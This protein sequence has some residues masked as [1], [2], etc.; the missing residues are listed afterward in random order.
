MSMF[1]GLQSAWSAFIDSPLVLLASLFLLAP[2]LAFLLARL[3]RV[4]RFC[5]LVMTGAMLGLAGS[6]IEGLRLQQ[7][8][9]PWLQAITVVLL[10][11]VGQR[12]SFGWLRRNP[13]L[14]MTSL[15]EFA[16]GVAVLAWLMVTLTDVRLLN[17]LIISAL[18]A[19]SSPVVVLAVSK[20]L[21]TRGQVTER[22]ILMSTLSTVLAVLLLQACLTAAALTASA[23]LGLVLA[24]LQQ[25]S[26]AFLLGLAGAALLLGIVRATRVR[27]AAQSMV[28][29]AACVMLYAVSQLFGISPLLAALLFGLMT[30]ALDRQHQVTNFEFSELGLLLAIAFFVLTGVTLDWPTSTG[31]LAIGVL[32]VLVR[33]AIKA[34]VQGGLAHFGALAPRRGLLVG[35]A[36]APLSGLSLL[37]AVDARISHP[38]L[39]VDSTVLMVV[40]L[41][42]AVIGPLLTE[43]A[44][45]LAHETTVSEPT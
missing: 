37:L 42:T 14:L 30:R 15:A 25:L 6:N 23:D 44:F 28:V 45:R 31:V 27:G 8:L 12:V 2:S 20:S 33:L 40:I 10:F 19:S 32:L 13:A 1:P 24:P 4:S 21:R 35:L 26:G 5:T 17:A 18:C 22:A 38:S 39:Q 34:G 7:S 36:M 29:V 43:V 41:I 16:V 11:E 3:L 9:V